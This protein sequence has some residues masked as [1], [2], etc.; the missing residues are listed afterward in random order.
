MQNLPFRK[1]LRIFNELYKENVD[2]YHSLAKHFGLSD[3]AF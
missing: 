1:F 2:I 3:C